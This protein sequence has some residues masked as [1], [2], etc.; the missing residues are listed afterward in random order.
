MSQANYL[1]LYEQSCLV[2]GTD[3]LMEKK[4]QDHLNKN[5]LQTANS[6]QRS[7]TVLFCIRGFLS[8]QKFMDRIKKILYL[9]TAQEWTCELAFIF[10]LQAS[11]RFCSAYQYLDRRGSKRPLPTNLSPLLRNKEMKCLNFC[12]YLL[13]HTSFSLYNLFEIQ[14]IS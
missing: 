13:L 8:R 10:G 1:L 9:V 7:L 12:L 5:L 6:E 4:N 14:V 2:E 3:Q 11:M